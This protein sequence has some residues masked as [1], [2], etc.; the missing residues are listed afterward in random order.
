M[1]R[2]N[3][4]NGKSI[5]I[6]DA[7]IGEEY[8][9]PVCGKPL[10]IKAKNSDIATHFA[11]KSKCLDDWSHDM[12]E[13]H[14]AWQEKFPEQYREIV[15]ENN[16]IKHR[17]DVLI[18]NTVIEFQHSPIT[19]K[20]ILARNEFYLSCG[21]RVV[22]VFDATDKIKNDYA[23]SID[24]MK[25]R[26]TDLCWKRT[27]QQFSSK[28]QEGVTKYIQYRT[29]VS[30]KNFEGMEFDILLLLNKVNSKEFTFFPTYY[31]IQR[32]NF[33]QEYGINTGTGA[34]SVSQILSHYNSNR[35]TV[36]HRLPVRRR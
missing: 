36:Y 8:F 1:F 34:P 27:K 24:P 15:L 35:P 17:A 13:W 22:W 14:K 5:L 28:F 2:A 12:S 16:G 6:D 29:P 21:Y 30:A 3:D 7:I 10:I 18:N 23:D 26:S 25:C 11:H 33:L 9:C 19:N 32:A 31:Y 20:E 4:K